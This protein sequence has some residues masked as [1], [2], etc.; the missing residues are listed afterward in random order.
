MLLERLVE[1]I[2]HC[3]PELVAEDHVED[4]LETGVDDGEYD[5]EEFPLGVERCA[6][7]THRA[8]DADRQRLVRLDVAQHHGLQ[9]VVGNQ[10]KNGYKTCK[11]K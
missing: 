2:E 7:E 4:E 6:G 8:V 3:P 9:D 1:A 10:A 11:R 5:D